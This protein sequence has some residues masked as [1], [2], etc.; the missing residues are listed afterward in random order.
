MRNYEEDSQYTNY[1]FR[2]AKYYSLLNN[3]DDIMELT[4]DKSDR[5]TNTRL[6]L[7]GDNGNYMK[8]RFNLSDEYEIREY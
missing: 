6:P 5:H 7:D 8:K 2:Y 3:F 1:L 4:L